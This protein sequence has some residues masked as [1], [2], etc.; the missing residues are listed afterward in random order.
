M[1]RLTT[2]GSGLIHHVPARCIDRISE[3]GTSSNW[4]GIRSTV[5]LTEG[6]TLECAETPRAILEM[7]E[8]E[9]AAERP[10]A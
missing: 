1:I 6:L 4:H 8:A 5:R 7:V 2:P 10:K 3:V 9:L